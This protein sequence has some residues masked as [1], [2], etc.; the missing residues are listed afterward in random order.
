MK[1]K[2]SSKKKISI[3]PRQNGFD[4]TGKIP[5]FNEV[6]FRA[7]EHMESDPR[8]DQAPFKMSPPLPDED[9]QKATMNS[10]PKLDGESGSSGIKGTEE[11]V[12]DQIRNGVAIDP[13]S[14]K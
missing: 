2:A 9:E 6:S 3:E 4:E 13:G 11:M 7:S 10:L 8:A 5:S 14:D 12:S 1:S